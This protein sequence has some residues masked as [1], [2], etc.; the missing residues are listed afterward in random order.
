M[1]YIHSNTSISILLTGVKIE[2]SGT[3]VSY[4]KS[5]SN[6][7]ELWSTNGLMVV[8]IQRLSGVLYLNMSKAFDLGYGGERYV[9]SGMD[10]SQSDTTSFTY[11][12]GSGTL[13]YSKIRSI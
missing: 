9:V 7:T 13:D 2:N 3:L 10:T 6:N 8:R 5:I 4:N 11:D 1:K 12:V